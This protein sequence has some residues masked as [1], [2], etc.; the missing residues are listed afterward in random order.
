MRERHPC[1]YMLASSFNGTI[2]IGVTS[3]RPARLYQHRNGTTGFA[4][5]YRACRLVH[6]EMFADMPNAIARE[7]QLKAWHRYWKKNLIERDNP[8]WEDLGIGLGIVDVL[9]GPEVDA[10]T[11]SA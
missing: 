1:V 4:S 7:K 9:P 2:Y 6:F 5:R 11:S 8:G 10:E 3:D